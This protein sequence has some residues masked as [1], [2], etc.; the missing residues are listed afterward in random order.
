[1]YARSSLGP[2]AVVPNAQPVTEE[3]MWEHVADPGWEPARTAA[4]VGL[5]R[6]VQGGTGTAMGGSTSAGA[7]RWQ[8]NAPQ[9]GFLR[10][11]GN[12]DEGWSARLDGEPVDVLRADGVF[13]GVQV[14]PG[15]H[16]V[17][18]SYLLPAESHGR[19]VAVVGLLLVL[20]IAFG[21]DRWWRRLGRTRRP[22]SARRSSTA[23]SPTTPSP[24]ERRRRV[25]TG[26]HVASLVVGFV[27]VV[28]V[29]RDQWFF[30]DEWAFLGP[31]GVLH[32]E[33]GLFAPHN[34]HWSTVPVLVYRALYSLFGVRS[35]LPYVVVLAV[36]HVAVAHLLWRVMRRSGVDVWVAT[37]L[38]VLFLFLGAGAENILWAFQIG[39]IGSVACGLGALLLL[40]RD[41]AFD[42]PP[43][44]REVAVWAVLVL[45]LMCSGIGVPM[46]AVA[47]VA[48]L[49][50][51]G[52]GRA[53]L[54]RAA[55]VVSV[56]GAV[57]L[58]WLV[59]AG[60][61]GIGDRSVDLSKLPAYLG[62]GVSN[63]FSSTLG[64]PLGRRRGGAGTGGVDGLAAEAGRDHLGAGVRL[65]GRRGPAVRGGGPGPRRP[66]H[67][68]GRG[69]AVRVPG[70]SPWPCR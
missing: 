5:A 61:D 57:Y 49:L 68:P 52:F 28:L 4:V 26:L 19:M 59:L 8:V 46:V 6:P 15:V 12:W 23:A 40:D 37:A 70:H 65:H 21:P 56:P 38:C 58:A 18:F 17:T 62:A 43:G 39:F 50:R 11:S 14:P 60:R 24:D 47:A 1:M 32:G 42:W 13:R 35:Y 48:V 67:R 31:R 36:V 41:T 45:G 29:N 2:A 7:E 27:G 3:E 33:P 34:E 55:L 69:V 54:R 51:R 63:A 44:R 30:G 66:R 16:E 10:V 22:G 9:G 53:G 20:G 25:A 64:S